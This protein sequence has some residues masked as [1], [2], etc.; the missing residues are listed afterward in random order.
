MVRFSDKALRNIILENI[1]NKKIIRLASELYCN[2]AWDENADEKEMELTT[3]LLNKQY[4]RPRPEPD[5]SR[6]ME[7]D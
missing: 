6:I 7:E 5:A 2:G 1:H 4:E 3:L